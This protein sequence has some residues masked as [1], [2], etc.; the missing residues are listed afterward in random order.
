MFMDLYIY[1]IPSLSLAQPIFHLT[2]A[3]IMAILFEEIRF[4]SIREAFKS[5]TRALLFR[6]Q[7]KRAK[8]RD[9]RIKAHDKS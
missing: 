2:Q 3:R 5:G 6:K 4:D 1:T 9:E 8:R 7:G